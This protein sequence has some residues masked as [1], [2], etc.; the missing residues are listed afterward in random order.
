MF[1]IGSSSDIGVA[2]LPPRDCIFP[3]CVA[4][5]A[6]GSCLLVNGVAVHCLLLRSVARMQWCGG[7][8]FVVERC[9]GTLALRLCAVERLLSLATC[10]HSRLVSVCLA[11]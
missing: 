7:I 3:S 1:V 5:F 11:L 9:G 6:F 2:A 4:A 8:Q 10:L